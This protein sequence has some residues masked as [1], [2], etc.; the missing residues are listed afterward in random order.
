MDVRT[1]VYTIYIY[2]SIDTLDYYDHVGILCGYRI[3]NEAYQMR[4]YLPTLK[5]LLKRICKFIGVHRDVIV[6]VVGDDNASKVDAI[7]TAC[8]ILMPV[9]DE[10]IPG[11]L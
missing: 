5:F 3:V 8:N 4:T 10:F 1:H 9:L 2:M 11:A 7:V 6:A